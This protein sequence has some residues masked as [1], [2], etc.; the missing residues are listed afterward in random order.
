MYETGAIWQIVAADGTAVTFNDGGGLILEEVTGFD[1]PDMRQNVTDLPEQDFAVAGAFYYSS[2]PFTMSGKIVN[3]P[4]AAVRNVLVASMQQAARGLRTDTT[5][6]SSPQGMPAMQVQARLVN[7]RVTGGFVKDFQFSFVAADGRIYSQDVTQTSASGS[8]ATTGAAFP[9]VF[10][11][12]FGGGTGSSATVNAV[13]AGN[14]PSPIVARV[15]GPIT[16]PVLTNTTTGESLYIDNV[17]L[18]AGEYIDVDMLNRTVT[19]NDGANL[20][21]NVRFPNS[22]WWLLQPGANNVALGSSTSSGSS[23]VTIS[24]RHVWV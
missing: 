11:I 10:P 1:S 15:S 13:N 9:L 18:I 6:K 2:R 20:Y 17:T 23:G 5:V 21:A 8:V 24:Y 14:F 4:S 3:Q 19:K 7:V 16:S 12:N 22:V